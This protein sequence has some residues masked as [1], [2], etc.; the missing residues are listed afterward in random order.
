M[1]VDGQQAAILGHGDHATGMPA[2]TL[3][4]SVRKDHRQWVS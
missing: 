1:G 2:P 4:M 3:Q